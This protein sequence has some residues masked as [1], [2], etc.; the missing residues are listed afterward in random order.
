MV[1][2]KPGGVGHHTTQGQN[3]KSVQSAPGAQLHGV[4]SYTTDAGTPT[5][6]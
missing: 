2:V 6:K 1:E 5:T 4:K 3:E